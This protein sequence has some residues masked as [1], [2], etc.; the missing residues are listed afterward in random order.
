MLG[1]IRARICQQTSEILRLLICAWPSHNLHRTAQHSPTMR[2]LET[3]KLL[4]ISDLLS[5]ASVDTPISCRLE[6][7][8]CKMTGVDKKMYKQVS[9]EGAGT[10]DL[11][12]LAPSWTDKPDA[13]VGTPISPP[14]TSSLADTTNRKTLYY[15]KSTLNESFAP[16]YDFSSCKSSQFSREPSFEFVKRSIN[17]NLLG[18]IGEAYHGLGHVLWVTLTGEIDPADC[19]IYSYTPDAD[20]DDPFVEHPSLWSF[21][22]FFYNRKLKRILLFA[23]QAS[24]AATTAEDDSEAVENFTFDDLDASP[25]RTA[26]SFE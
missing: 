3:P 17:S 16:D 15:L 18:S 2:L 12:T 13:S 1:P 14:T 24:N 23:C 5:S 6:S 9:S 4:H 11:E 21:C 20:S 8:S 25:N 19:E 10:E 22:F 7:Y 26:L